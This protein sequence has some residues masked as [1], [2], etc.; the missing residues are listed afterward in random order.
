[1]VVNTE[2]ISVDWK[3]HGQKK[4]DIWSTLPTPHLRVQGQRWRILQSNC[5]LNMIGPTQN[6]SEPHNSCGGLYMNC[7]KSSMSTWRGKG[8]H[9]PTSSWGPMES[10]QLLKEEIVS[11]RCMLPV[12]QGIAR[13]PSAYCQHTKTKTKTQKT[14][15]N[16]SFKNRKK[17]D[18]GR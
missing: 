7:T 1:M 12:L 11:F 5:L 18:T 4:W 6:Y 16:R 17:E 8:S 15:F 14:R 13:H 3:V 10:W 2:T 9:T